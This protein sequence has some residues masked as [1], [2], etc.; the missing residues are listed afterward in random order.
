MTNKTKLITKNVRLQIGKSGVHFH[1][2]A[3]DRNNFIKTPLSPSIKVIIAQSKIWTVNIR[4]GFNF[5]L[6]VPGTEWYTI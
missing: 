3:S 6:K 4:S 5:E 1:A 2:I